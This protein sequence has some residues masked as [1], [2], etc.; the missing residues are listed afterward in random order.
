MAAL[1]AQLHLTAAERP[2]WRR[3]EQTAPPRRAS[4][5]SGS[6]PPR[7]W[8][9]GGGLGF[10]QTV[11]ID[12][13]SANGIRPNETVIN[14]DGLVGRTIV[15]GRTDVD[16]PA[17]RRPDARRSGARPKAPQLE[18]GSVPRW[19]PGKPCDDVLDAV[20]RT[21]DSPRR[22]AGDRGSTTRT[23]LEPFVPEVPIGRVTQV[24]PPNGGLAQT[25]TV[26]PFV[27]YSA[28]D[29]VARRRARARATVKHDSL[30]P[31]PPTP[32]P[33]V[34]VTVTATP[35]RRRP[36]GSS[37]TLG[38]ALRHG[39]R[40]RARDSSATGFWPS[41]WRP[42]CCRWSWSTGCRCRCGHP[43]LLVLVVIAIG[44]ASG[45]AARRRHRV[46]RRSG[47]RLDAALPATSPGRLA[48]AYTLVGYLAGLLEDAEEPQ[49][50][51]HLRRGRASASPCWCTPV[52]A[53]L[54]GDPVTARNV[55][56]RGCTVVY[57]VVL[58]P[59]VVPPVSAVARR[60][61]PVGS[62]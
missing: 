47:G 60:L 17:R 52:S 8:R 24:T 4:R 56:G 16:R 54:V 35:V 62:R 59:F 46:R 43:D 13:G 12:R 38:D 40:A 9:I 28:L 14:G 3:T 42:R 55:S 11:T 25:G 21:A 45:P 23:A 19:W 20:Q 6:W 27:D 36:V 41:C 26:Q 33:T 53:L 50:D 39:T 15:V 44:L 18:L 61:E 48:F 34:T 10:D 30:L 22:A 2:S 5:S 29:V 32:A 51:D 1:Q 7:W 58:A 49:S 37:A 57:D 31:A